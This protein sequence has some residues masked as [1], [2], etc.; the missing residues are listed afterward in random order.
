MYFF[1]VL[2]EETGTKDEKR[3]AWTD[4]YLPCCCLCFLASL[5]LS[6]RARWRSLSSN[7]SSLLP[8][9]LAHS[10]KSPAEWNEFETRLSIRKKY[11]N[12]TRGERILGARTFRQE[13]SLGAGGADLQNVLLQVYATLMSLEHVQAQQHVHRLF[14]ENAERRGQVIVPD[15]YLYHV[16]TADYALH[17]YAF[18]DTGPPRVH[19]PHNVAPLGASGGHYRRLCTWNY[20]RT[21]TEEKKACII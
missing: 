4:T 19:Q 16:Y 13:W 11:Y 3:I 1:F 5:E 21:K 8:L 15:L 2:T 17:A 18:G 9:S 7:D 12:I 6:S 14:L 10:G 20:C